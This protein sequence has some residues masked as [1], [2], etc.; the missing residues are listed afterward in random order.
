MDCTFTLSKSRIQLDGKQIAREILLSFTKDFSFHL[1]EEVLQ[2]L[3]QNEDEFS[4]HYA[5]L[6]HSFAEKSM[7]LDEVPNYTIYHLEQD[8]IEWINIANQKQPEKLPMWLIQLNGYFSGAL[9][10]VFFSHGVKSDKSLSITNENLKASLVQEKYHPGIHAYLKHIESGALMDHSLIRTE[11]NN[12]SFLEQYLKRENLFPKKI[13][14]MGQ[15][16]NLQ[17]LY[18]IFATEL[19]LDPIELKNLQSWFTLDLCDTS[20][21]EIV[22]FSTDKYLFV[23]I[24]ILKHLGWENRSTHQ[25]IR[26]YLYFD[27]KMANSR[28]K[29]LSQCIT[30]DGKSLSTKKLDRY[31]ERDYLET[32]WRELSLFEVNKKLKRII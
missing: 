10:Y 30:V 3:R 15:P 8:L 17:Q 25:A 31:S 4:Q 11:L 18:Q 1:D 9:K 27:D 19:N 20:Q 7:S 29:W 28:S 21:I 5:N 22:N 24:H 13:H 32:K 6:L 23:L 16:E 26:N 14:W 2:F 12:Y